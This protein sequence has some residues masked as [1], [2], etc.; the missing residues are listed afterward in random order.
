MIVVREA[1]LFLRLEASERGDFD[2][3]EFSMSELTYLGE[4]EAF[5]RGGRFL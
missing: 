3:S 1:K 4:S 5:S 2:I